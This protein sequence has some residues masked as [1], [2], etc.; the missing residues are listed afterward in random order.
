[1]RGGK[2]KCSSKRQ[3]PA[4]I[5]ERCGVKNGRDPNGAVQ[6]QLDD[7]TGKRNLKKKLKENVQK[8]TIE[9]NSKKFKVFFEKIGKVSYNDIRNKEA[10]IISKIKGGRHYEKTG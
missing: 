1:M 9:K 3:P 4:P 8:M 6:N 10:M 5:S 2:Q 7:G